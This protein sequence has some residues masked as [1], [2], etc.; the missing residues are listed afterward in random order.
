MSAGLPFSFENSTIRTTLDVR[1]YRV[2]AVKKAAYRLADRCS[3]ALG[4]L[5][6][7]CLPLVFLFKET[8]KPEAALATVGA[9][10]QEVTDQ[11]LREHIAEETGPLRA[12]ILAHAFSNTDLIDQKVAPKSAEAE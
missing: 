7:T 12:L 5:D 3:V 2:T 4:P 6:G 1:V 8:T 10:Y 11:E 9:F